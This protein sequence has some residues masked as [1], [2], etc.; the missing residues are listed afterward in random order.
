MRRRKRQYHRH[1]Q[2]SHLHG[3]DDQR[4]HSPGYIA[5]DQHE[6][7]DHDDFDRLL[8]RVALGLPIQRCVHDRGRGPAGESEHPAGEHDARQHHAVQHDAVEHDRQRRHRSVDRSGPK[9]P[10]SFGLAYFP[11]VPQLGT[12]LVISVAEY[13]TRV[14]VYPQPY[15]A[16]L[17]ITAWAKPSGVVVQPVARLCR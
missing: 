6:H 11:R 17:P 9:P 15:W 10:G 16:R 1:N 12:A 8:S 14:P 13:S 4:R 3:A 5:G 2:R 7:G